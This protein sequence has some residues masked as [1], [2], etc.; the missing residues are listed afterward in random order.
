MKLMSSVD[1]QRKDFSAGHS[2]PIKSELGKALS[3]P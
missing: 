2:F 1:P 3:K